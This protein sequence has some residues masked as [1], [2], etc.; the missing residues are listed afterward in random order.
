MFAIF[1]SIFALLLSFG[2]LLLANGLFNSLLG[3]RAN[4]EGMSSTYVGMIMSSH[5]VGM[6][7]GGLYAGRVVAGVGHIRA[8][9]AFASML[10]VAA[11]MHAIFIDLL[12][13]MALRLVSGFCTAGM[14]IVTESWINERSGSQYRGSVLATYMMVNYLGNGSG[15]MLLK[16]GDISEFHL[17]SLASIIFS[18]ALIPVLLT[19]QS[20]PILERGP[21]MSILSVLR[22]GPLAVVGI[23]TAGTINSSINALAPIYAMNMYG[24]ASQAANFTAIMLISGFVLQWPLGRLSDYVG[25]GIL[26]AGVA[27][28]IAICSLGMVFSA[29][30]LP[31]WILVMAFIYGAFLY[32][33]YSLCSALINDVI[34]AK[35]R[36][37]V[38]GTILII[39]GIGAITGP[40]LVG[41]LTDIV[42]SQALFLFSFTASSSLAAFAIYRR[43]HQAIFVKPV[44]PFVP[45]PSQQVPTDELYLA[46]QEDL[47]NLPGASLKDN[48]GVVEGEHQ[49]Q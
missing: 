30:Y 26:I 41:M 29:H 15:Q 23:F 44:Q 12:P 25:R 35:L 7:I 6:L 33:L 49:S 40:M 31:Q 17:F 21:R 9:A 19:R 10:S 34:G 27:V 36:V 48:E 1:R 22:L 32:T 39:Y 28:A 4:Q 16:L 46:A 20:A 13:W 11:L 45:V 42:G 18:L 43:I 14:L 24:N 8:F 37:S 3:L 5:F 2:L 38:T 47:Q